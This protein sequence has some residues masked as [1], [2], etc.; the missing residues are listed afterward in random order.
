MDCYPL[1]TAA[2]FTTKLPRPI[3]LEGEWEV[4]LTEISVTIMFNNV[5][6]DSCFLV[7]MKDMMVCTRIA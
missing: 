2:Q 5:K 6:K 4:A 7:L 3:S 1:N